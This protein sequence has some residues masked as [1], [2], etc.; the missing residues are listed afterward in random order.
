MYCSY[1]AVCDTCKELKW[2]LILKHFGNVILK[3]LIS[4]QTLCEDKISEA[5]LFVS[6]AI[7]LCKRK[8]ILTSTTQSIWRNTLCTWLVQRYL[9]KICRHTIWIINALWIRYELNP[10]KSFFHRVGLWSNSPQ[11]GIVPLSISSTSDK[12]YIA[13]EGSLQR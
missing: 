10:R 8:L 5:T 6:I 7:S 13:S 11:N 4:M 12:A 3:F 9:I 2:I 1:D